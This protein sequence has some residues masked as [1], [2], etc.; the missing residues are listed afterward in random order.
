M[1]GKNVA[2][3]NKCDLLQEMEAEV[4]NDRAEETS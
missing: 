3:L 2:S 1:V 4:T